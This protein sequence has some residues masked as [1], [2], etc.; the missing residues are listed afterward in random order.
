MRAKQSTSRLGGRRVA[1]A[2]HTL[3]L[4]PLFTRALYSGTSTSSPRTSRALRS[5][6]LATWSSSS[7]PLRPR[8]GTVHRTITH[9]ARDSLMTTGKNIRL[10][11]LSMSGTTPCSTLNPQTFF[12]RILRFSISVTRMLAGQVVWRGFVYAALMT[13]GKLMCGIAIV[14]V[15]GFRSLLRAGKN[16][17]Q[18]E[19]SSNKK[20]TR[21]AAQLR[22]DD[23]VLT[24]HQ[25][26][27]KDP[28][29]KQRPPAPRRKPAANVKPCL[30]RD[31][32]TQ[33]S[34][35]EVQW[36]HV[37][38]SAPSSA[39]SR[40][41]RESSSPGRRARV[42]TGYPAMHDPWIAIRG[43]YGAQGEETST[44]RA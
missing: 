5:A 32:S 33:R 42:Q 38:R 36:S 1:L 12:L 44:C 40:R 28:T 30:D 11:R 14:R 4:L 6:G 25:S 31:R 41:A 34:C 16:K 18:P 26:G 8:L 9:P 13:I 10:A 3:V 27:D 15:P 29:P 22:N 21:K 39:L 19:K 17:R 35:S 24:P 37:A 23:N 7:L 43:S 20:R 2:M